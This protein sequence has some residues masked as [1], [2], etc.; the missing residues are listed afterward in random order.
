GEGAEAGALRDGLRERLPQHMIPA[1]F[2]FLD[3]LPLTVHGKVD[4]RALPAPVR[5]RPDEALV[6]P[7]NA[8]EELLARVWR[9]VLRVEAVGVH[10]NFFELGGDSILSIQVVAR[11][12]RAGCR[13]KP[14]QIF[15]YQ[16]IAGL[17]EVADRVSESEADQGPV[18]GPVPLSPIQRRYLQSRPVAPHHFTQ[19]SLLAVRP[20]ITPEVA[21]QAFAF[22]LGHHDALRL[23]FAEEAGSW[24]QRGL[25][26]EETKAAPWSRLDLS[27]L[28][29][30]RG[31]TALEEVAADVQASL[32]LERGPIVR[33]V[34]FDLPDGEARLF[35]V[36]HHLAVDVVSWGIL[37]E[38]LES[39][40]RSLSGGEAVE[41]PAKTTSFRSWSEKLAGHARSMPL[42]PELS[43]WLQQGEGAAGGLP[44]DEPD[45]ADTEASARWVSIALS[46]DETDALLHKVPKAYRTQINDVLLT[47]LVQALAG[48]GGSLRIALEGHGREEILDGV[49]LSRTVG[50]FT[51]VFPVLLALDPGA[52][53]DPGAAL[54]AVKEQLR[55]IPARGI[56]YGLLRYLREEE[57]VT[58]RLAG[59]PHPEVS[60]NYQGQLDQSLREDTLFR[61]AG[62]ARGPHRSPGA[63]RGHRLEVGGAVTGGQLQI[64]FGYSENVYHRST[65]EGLAGRFASHLRA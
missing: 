20:P 12:A 17:A 22:L 45:G 14:R 11:A 60:F 36:V 5:E 37:L 41:L 15:E 25:G 53:Q 21:R 62:E 54:L 58:G 44:P 16:T 24:R 40:C 43:W 39:A 7:R 59:L 29:P 28:A 3:S 55:S 33:G 26:T 1:H 50:W 30:D 46:A 31:R 2:V 34:W 51:T 4:H 47:A 8:V 49:D 42:E 9:E 48:P 64:L 63:A 13:I 56:G 10:D 52:P 19:S 18:A 35:L 27:G 6:A 23:R 57:G 61:P 38:D 65:M 32:D